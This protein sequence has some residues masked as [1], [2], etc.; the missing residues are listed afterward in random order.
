MYTINQT[1]ENGLNYVQIVGA[2]ASAKICLDRGVALE[3][4]VLNQI[5]VIV[6]LNPLEYKDTYASSILFPFANRIK[7]GKYD[8]KGKTFQLDCNEAN[9]NNALHGLVYDKLFTVKNSKTSENSASVILEYVET[10]KAV[11]FPYLFTV[12]VT[13]TLTQNGLALQLGVENNDVTSFPFT[14]GWHPY[15]LSDD[16]Y[17]SSLIFSSNKSVEFDERMITKNI[18]EGEV[19]MPLE[20]KDKQLD[21]CYA[22]DKSAV[23]FATPKYKMTIDS[24]AKE[25][26]FQMY[27]PPKANTIA[28]EPV[29]GVS[30]SL[31][32]QMGV[33]ELSAGA[34][35]EITW[36]VTI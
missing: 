31:N 20:I 10:N 29:T 15:F 5:P 11:G 25:N 2:N 24:T 13:Y 16:L 6:D 17:N 27:T 12:T 36:T 9:L 28:L 7:D 34:S 4:L 19:A 14:L 8:Y 3:E 1:Q 26:F 30:N 23:V 18:V 22:L 33:Q 32:N 21:N 35:Y